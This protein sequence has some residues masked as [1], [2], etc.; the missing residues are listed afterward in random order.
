VPTTS[1]RR[2]PSAR[3]ADRRAA[4]VAAGALSCAGLA[5]A[6]VLMAGPAAALEDTRRPVADVSHGPSCGPG[7]VGVQ[8]VNGSE[9]HR[10]ALVFDGSVEHE[11]AD[12]GPGER[13][14]LGS[15]DVDWGTTVAVSVTVADLDGTV[16][17]PLDLGTYTRPSREDCDGLVPL[18]E[19]APARTPDGSPAPHPNPA[20]GGSTSAPEP[21]TVPAANQV[22]PPLTS[23]TGSAAAEQAAVAAVAPGGVVTVRGSGFAAGETVDVSLAGAPG[24]LAAVVAADD[25]SVEAVVQIPR[26]AELGPLT[27]QLVGRTSSA[28]SGLDLQVAARQQSLAPASDPV[29]VV[30]AGAALL[31]AGAAVGAAVARRPRAAAARAPAAWR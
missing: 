10:V 23:S 11:V 20:T 8:V 13:V 2:S 21:R 3:P 16:E 15:P 31:V 30:A 29:P 6:G 22:L 25:G 24:A 1:V 12:L 4:L 17:L 27:V 14:E 28:T 7:V 19:A 18:P 5:V 26:A 9:P